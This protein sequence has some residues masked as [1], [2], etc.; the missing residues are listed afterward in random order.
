MVGRVQSEAFDLG[1]EVARLTAGRIDTGAVVTFTGLC[2]GVDQ[3]GV[4]G[5]MTLETYEPMTLAEFAR[6]ETE[7]RALAPPGRLDHPSPWPA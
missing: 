7:A 5:A 4:I 3:D 6:I 1:V 2:R